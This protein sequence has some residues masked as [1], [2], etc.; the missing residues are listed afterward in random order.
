MFP[1]AR[2]I[3]WKWSGSTASRNTATIFY[4]TAASPSTPHSIPGAG[5]HR[6]GKGPPP[7]HAPAQNEQ[8]FPRPLEYLPQAQ[9]PRG[10]FLAHFDSVLP[11]TRQHATRCPIP[12]PAHRADRAHCDGRE[13]RRH[14]FARR[15]PQLPRKQVQ[16]AVQSVRQ[17]GSAFKPIVYTAAID[18]GFTPASVVLDQPSRS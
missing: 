5:F 3:L 15:R 2:P 1:S 18:N 7:R 16:P 14:P 10:T 6:Q 11:R 8:L 12:A 13:K 17:P 9:D 4:T